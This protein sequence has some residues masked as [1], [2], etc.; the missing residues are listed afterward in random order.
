MNS[1][2]KFSR[3]NDEDEDGDEAN[4]QDS[5]SDLMTDLL[6][7][8]VILFSFAMMS[9]AIEASK[10]TSANGQ[11]VIAEF[12]ESTILPSHDSILPGQD[13]VLPDQ[14]S[15]NNLYEYIKAYIN[16]TGLSN[17]L[18]VTKQGNKEIL[19]RVAASVFFD[20]GRAD[21]NPTAEPLL[22]KISDIL[23]V[24]DDSIKIIRIEGHTDNLPINTKQFDSNWELSTSRAVNVLRRLLEI[25]E[26]EPKKFSAVGYSEFYPI[27]DNDTTV[28]RAKNRRVDFFIEAA[29][30]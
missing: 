10:S 13:S 7:I 18:S 6:A 16:E 23:T 14:E 9:Q 15:F 3:L 20:S 28:G 12:A 27:A 24:Y 2:S 4:W 25:S 30:E 26:F 22:N 17:Q 19:L 8:F 5:Y 11:N 29:E 1:R 21:I